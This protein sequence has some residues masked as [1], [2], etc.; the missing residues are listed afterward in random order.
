MFIYGSKI[1]DVYQFFRQQYQKIKKNV[2][3]ELSGTS[4][5]VTSTP[6]KNTAKPKDNTPKSKGKGGRARTA[7][8]PLTEDDEAS[9]SPSKRFKTEP[10][11]DGES[12]KLD[13]FGDDMT[14]DPSDTM[15]SVT[16]RY[17]FYSIP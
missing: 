7:T 2:D 11:T 5:P 16:S 6:K 10:N 14:E 12:I 4:E 17:V 1:D 15:R 9:G 13:P 3:Q 8:G